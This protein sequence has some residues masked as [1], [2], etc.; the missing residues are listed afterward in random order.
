MKIALTG[1]SGFIGKHLV[2]K[3]RDNHHDVIE[4]NS[5]SG[6]IADEGTWQSFPQVDVVIHLAGRTF[7]PDSWLDSAGFLKTNFLGTIAALEYCKNNDARL[8]YLS[9]YLYGNPEKLPISESAP[10]YAN[11]PYALSKKLTEEACQFYSDSFG[12]KI[13]VLRPFNVY[14][15]GQ[16]ELFLIPSII[17]QTSL[18]DV[19]RVKDLEPKRDYVYIDDLV[20]AIIKAIGLNQGFSVFNIGT[21]LSYSV[22][23]LIG[24]IQEI[25]GSKLTC[26]SSEERRPDEILDC[27]ADIAQAT[28]CLG[29]KPETDLKSGLRAVIEKLSFPGFI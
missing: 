6:D 18:G 24:L 12:V 15:P 5:R 16:S 26:I 20:S 3:L 21:G 28:R 4:A 10:L 27:R 25:K 19:I 11:N 14:G 7:V 22:A 8:V 1:A 29:W 2:P 17:D 13:T 9:S 23:E